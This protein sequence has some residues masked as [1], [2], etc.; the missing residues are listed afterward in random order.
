LLNNAGGEE[1]NIIFRQ[2]DDAV[3]DT[4]ISSMGESSDGT[5]I[6]EEDLFA[7]YD[8]FEN[9][10]RYDLRYS[11]APSYLGASSSVLNP[12]CCKTPMVRDFVIGLGYLMD[13]KALLHRTYAIP[14]S[15]E[16]RLKTLAV[17]LD[18][19]YKEEGFVDLPC[20][21]MDL[22]Q[23]DNHLTL[24]K[25]QSARCLTLLPIQY[26][27]QKR[28]ESWK[29]YQ[30]NLRYSLNFQRERAYRLNDELMNYFFNFQ[31]IMTYLC[32]Y[33]NIF[34]FEDLNALM[35]SFTKK[36]LMEMAWQ[37]RVKEA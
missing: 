36:K 21:L 26:M 19:S 17:L 10:M 9:W 24:G 27:V 5:V 23:G 6:L 30:Q 37:D 3:S 25:T 28:D 20:R 14:S 34:F 32:L 13:F 15:F 7:I 16:G 18:D 22:L 1:E 11:Y 29:Q 8:P 31:D 35:P 12:E 2:D 4:E 33:E